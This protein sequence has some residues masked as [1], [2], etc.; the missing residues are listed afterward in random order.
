MA[1]LYKRLWGD[2][3]PYRP[4][5]D[6]GAGK[7]KP[8][9]V[10]LDAA[11]PVYGGVLKAL[12]TTE[13]E[14]G[15]TLTAFMADSQ[16]RDR[17]FAQRKTVATSLS[18]PEIAEEAKELEK[19][20][21]ILKV[22]A[23][24]NGKLP[25][26]FKLEDVDSGEKDDGAASESLAG[27]LPAS[28]QAAL[29]GVFGFLRKAARE[30]PTLCVEPL[31]I[32]NALV[33][34]LDPQ[35]M[36]SE[37]AETLRS[38]HGFFSSL[39]TED[40]AAASLLGADIPETKLVPSSLS[41][42]TSLAVVRGTLSS[43]LNCVTTLLTHIGKGEAGASIKF[44]TPAPLLTLSKVAR[45]DSAGGSGKALI[46]SDEALGTSIDIK[47]PD[48]AADVA[49]GSPVAIAAH[50][51]FVYVIIAKLDALV[52]VGTGIGSS[53]RG[54]VYAT[55][56]GIHTIL[57]AEGATPTSS[58]EDSLVWMGVVNGSSTKPLI[59]VREQGMRP[60]ELLAFAASDLELIGVFKQGTSIV[61]RSFE[62][63]ES[64]GAVDEADAKIAASGAG[65]LSTPG[66]LGLNA[67]AAGMIT[68][69]SFVVSAW[70]LCGGSMR[71]R[72]YVGVCS[73]P[74]RVWFSGHLLLGQ[75]FLLMWSCLFCF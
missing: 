6:A 16:M 52:K 70:C 65:S 12:G 10:D 25:A 66:Q 48:L 72:C 34:S 30:N 29:A 8:A 60:G 7:D 42:L 64:K 5:S 53:V 23:A 57:R 50:G 63:E 15:A 43:V 61:G 74:V 55:K 3:D 39:C 9:P 67:Y 56:T 46:P 21:R 22:F 59:V 4:S 68:D 17:V 62:I 18:A 28:V 32:M 27:S 31:D 14:S 41:G 44:P 26:D 47:V 20:K 24:N 58:L 33:S 40:M 19:A 45:D 71:A 69:N 51:A 1:A 35:A 73:G 54:R 37:K 49:A 75:R 38:M 13:R 2:A 11:P 36:L